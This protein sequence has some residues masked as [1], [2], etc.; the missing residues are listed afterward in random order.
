MWLALR[1]LTS[2]EKG[3][4]EYSFSHVSFCCINILFIQEINLTAD[5]QDKIYKTS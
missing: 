3:Q 4:G 5:V 2:V 1:F